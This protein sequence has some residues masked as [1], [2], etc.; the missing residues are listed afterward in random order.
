[1]HE[2][3]AWIWC[4]LGALSAGLAV[5]LGALGA[6]WGGESEAARGWIETAQ[7]YHMPNA[8][9]LILIAVLTLLRPGLLLTLAGLGLL[10]GSLCF[11]GGLYLQ[12]F[13]LLRLGPVVPLGGSLLILGWLLLAAHAIRALSATKP[14]RS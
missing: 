1:M 3:L 8:L 5:V 14:E 13:D 6:H 2:R 11:S 12:G 4:L 10:V 9:G 7:S